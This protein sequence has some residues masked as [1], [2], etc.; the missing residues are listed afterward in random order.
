MANSNSKTYKSTKY[1][2]ACGNPDCPLVTTYKP[3]WNRCPASPGFGVPTE[4]V[5]VK[6]PV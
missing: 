1:C 5:N 2:N 4:Q 6:E 3:M